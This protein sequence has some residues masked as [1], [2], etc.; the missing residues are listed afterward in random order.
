MRPA[1]RTPSGAQTA[2]A[3]GKANAFLPLYAGSDP[4]ETILVQSTHQ[5][6]TSSDFTP[7]SE[8]V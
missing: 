4:R 3:T 1:R 5:K 2:P 7:F 6:N 8:C